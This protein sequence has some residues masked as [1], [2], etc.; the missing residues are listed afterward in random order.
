MEQVKLLFDVKTIN[1]ELENEFYNFFVKWDLL[2][3][4]TDA[5]R[6]SSITV[7]DA[8]A[9][10]VTNYGGAYNKDLKKLSEL[11]NYATTNL[12]YQQAIFSLIEEPKSFQRFMNKVRKVNNY[13]E[14]EIRLEHQFNRWNVVF[15]E[16]DLK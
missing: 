9:R 5:H 14:R 7:T 15:Y 10:A 16:D 12:S 1:E 6:T 4:T 8:D 2:A 3:L 11:M 13:I